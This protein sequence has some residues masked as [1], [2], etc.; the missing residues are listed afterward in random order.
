[1]PLDKALFEQ[2]VRGQKPTDSQLGTA[3]KAMLA[4]ELED[5][6]IS[7][8]LLGLEMVGTDSQ[9]LRTGTDILHAHM[10]P[11]DLG[12][13]LIDIVG[14]GGSG[15]N[16]L[17]IST[18][19]ALVCAGT[20]LKVAK[21]GNR[22]ASSLAGTADV[23][24]ALGV[25]VTLDEEKTQQCMQVANMAFLFAPNYHP[26]MRHVTQA[27]QAIAVRTIF[28]LIGPL[29]NPARAQ[30]HLIGVC[31]KAWQRPMAETLSAFGYQRA[32]IVHGDDGLDEISLCAPTSVVELKDGNI[33]Q[34][35]IH[36][37]EL[38]LEYVSLEAIKGGTPQQ[39]AGHLRA[40]LH[41]Q[42]SA[43][44]DITCLN[45]AAALVISGQANTL[46]EGIKSA[47]KSIDSGAAQTVLER[48]IAIS[49]E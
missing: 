27:R 20:G 34:F 5:A 4:G 26:A 28:N 35:V 9:D 16:T 43:Y 14:T 10:R 24:E 31:R 41:G 49:H 12:S 39:N 40:L 33:S 19:S 8:F 3:L 25:N 6:Q 7:A 42:R 22:F 47:A 15:L 21:H 36:P 13:S 29:C 44:R 45:S 30:Y 37:P 18:A 1:M 48:L 46:S 23:L 38:G 2:F 32:W 11:I 17:S